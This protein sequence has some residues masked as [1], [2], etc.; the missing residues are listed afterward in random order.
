[1]IARRACWLL[2]AAALGGCPLDP[3]ATMD[4]SQRPDAADILDLVGC[5]AEPLDSDGIFHDSTCSPVLHPLDLDALTWES[6]GIYEFDLETVVV[7]GGTFYRFYYSGAGQTYGRATGLASSDRGVAP[8]R[9]TGNPLLTPA[10]GED[11]LTVACL[12]HDAQADT[13]H[14]WFRRDDGL[15]H[16]TSDDGIAWAADEPVSGMTSDGDGLEVP[17]G[18]DAWFEDGQVR[19]LVGGRFGDSTYAI[20]ETR[21]DDGVVF[22]PVDA[23]VY[24]SSVD[25]PW[26]P[27]GVAHPSRITWNGRE[28]LFSIGANGWDETD[29]AFPDPLSPSI[30]VA[31]RE[32]DTEPYSLHLANPLPG[33]TEDA[34]PQRV[35]AVTVGPWAMVYVRDLFFGPKIVE[36]P[37][38]SIGLLLVWL[39]GLE[40]TS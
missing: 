12:A 18:C 13:F 27:A 20:G 31:S 15:V 37:Q 26:Q 33:L 11:I 4:W 34:E 32:S 22:D 16:S 5:A 17:L 10:T 30:G 39:P 29:P 2:L 24:S 1:M 35:R 6:W 40:S 36:N 23:P 7:F 3:D 9:H 38:D 25:S 8:V 14:G 28:Y 21:S 19:M